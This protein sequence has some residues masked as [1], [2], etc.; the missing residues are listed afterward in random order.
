MSAAE[1]AYA[2]ADAWR[3]LAEAAKDAWAG[4]ASTADSLIANNSG[5]AID[6]FEE[7]WREVSSTASPRSLP[8][9]VDRCVKLAETCEKY[10]VR[11]GTPAC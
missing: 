3:A 7:R 5:A 4:T 8:L 6:A 10:A 9:L 2:S 1:R 11:L